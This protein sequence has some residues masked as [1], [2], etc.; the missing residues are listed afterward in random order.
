M[1][2]YESVIKKSHKM[3]RIFLK[4]P[5]TVARSFRAVHLSLYRFIRHFFPLTYSISIVLDIHISA[6]QDG[7]HD[8]ANEVGI[9]LFVARNFFGRIKRNHKLTG[10]LSKL[11]M[12]DCLPIFMVTF[13]LFTFTGKNEIVKK[14]LC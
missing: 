4:C 2:I 10:L 1:L 3:F 8:L 7:I 6:P 12:A 14:H 5:L 13:L 11:F 9:N